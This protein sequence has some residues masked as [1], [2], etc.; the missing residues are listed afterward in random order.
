MSLSPLR[1]SRVGMMVY[2][3]FYTLINVNVWKFFTYIFEFEIDLSS[4]YAKRLALLPFKSWFRIEGY[5]LLAPASG[6][7]TSD[8]YY[9]NGILV[10]G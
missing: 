4:A 1:R 7:Q 8:L 3:P 10:S 2:F 9:S 6:L 5:G